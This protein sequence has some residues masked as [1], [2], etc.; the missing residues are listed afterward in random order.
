MKSARVWL[1]LVPA[2]I[3]ILGGLALGYRSGATIGTFTSDG[4]CP[5]AQHVTSQ[6]HV[7][8]AERDK[9]LDI[10]PTLRVQMTGVNPPEPNWD[11]LDLMGGAFHFSECFLPRFATLTYIEWSKGQLTARFDL[12][13]HITVDRSPSRYADEPPVTAALG[14]STSRIRIDLCRPPKEELESRGLVCRDDAD[15]TINIRI[16]NPK[17]LKT[18]P[19]AAPFPQRT[20]QS[21]GHADYS[22]IFSGPAPPVSV[23]MDT[24]LTAA[25]TTYLQSNAASRFEVTSSDRYTFGLNLNY[26]AFG[27]SAVTALIMGACAVRDPKTILKLIAIAVGTVTLGGLWLRLDQSPSTYLIDY[28]PFVLLGWFFITVGIARIRTQLLA[29]FLLL[30]GLAAALVLWIVPDGPQ[31]ATPTFVVLAVALLALTVT[32]VTQIFGQVM[33]V[34]DVRDD[35]RTTDYQFRNTL[36]AAA[37]LAAC[38]VLTFPV[39]SA[40]GDKND[41]TPLPADIAHELSTSGQAAAHAFIQLVPL[42]VV[43]V[44]A[45]Y[46][47]PARRFTPAKWSLPIGACALM[48]SLAAPWSDAGLLV[49]V[50]AIPLWLLQ[51]LVL[52]L[53]QRRFA[54]RTASPVTE[55]RQALLAAVRA[56]AAEHERI[57]RNRKANTD[58]PRVDE[59]AVSPTIDAGRQLVALGPCD[60]QLATASFAATRAGYI[61]VVPVAYFLWNALGALG[62]N[63]TFGWGALIILT[64]LLTEAAR[65]IVAGFVF[66]YFYPKLLGRIG[67]FKALEFAG[68]WVLSAAVPFAVAHAFGIDMLNEFI[69][70]SAQ[71]ALFIIVLAIVMD[72]A[73]ITKARGGWRDLQKVYALHTYG[74]TVAAVVPAALL[75]ITLGQQI[76][77]GSAFD[78]AASFL[79]GITDVIK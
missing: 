61:A 11:R 70:R 42:I 10:H 44:L 46:L 2:V 5:S 28:A 24:P 79:S 26:L 33:H 47:L 38:A 14:M 43:S 13:D 3:G 31:S 68:L 4:P 75:V 58:A 49:V 1:L 67:P 78:V 56:E 39:G 52:W 7:D 69:Y 20:D 54:T 9:K 41:T 50:I 37:V 34:F 17:S 65:W 55:S 76:L 74:E 8:V 57:R 30:T 36:T 18:Q 12:S 48:L 51:W 15:T 40:L 53:G 6:I 63:L 19:I 77:A 59:D 29:T 35:N 16:N 73:T 72:Y 32:A 25:A 23:S 45:V 66:G 22:W 60:G 64:G 71:F 21:G 62:A 27:A